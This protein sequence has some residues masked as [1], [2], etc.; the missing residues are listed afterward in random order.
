MAVELKGRPRAKVP[1][2][3]SSDYR[4]RQAIPQ[5]TIE[6]A[7]GGLFA[8]PKHHRAVSDFYALAPRGF[9]A[10]TGSPIPPTA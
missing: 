5:R 8:N 1:D 7:A 3:R 4:L 2:V 6:H 9:F 10:R